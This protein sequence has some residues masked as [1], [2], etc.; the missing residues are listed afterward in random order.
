MVIPGHGEAVSPESIFQRPV[1]MDSGLAVARRP[2]MTR[3]TLAGAKTKRHAAGSNRAQ[4]SLAWP[5]DLGLTVASHGW[6]HL[7]PWVWEPETGTLRRLAPDEAV[8]PPSQEVGA[9]PGSLVRD[10]ELDE[11]VAGHRVEPYA[12]TSVR[13]RVPHQVGHRLLDLTPVGLHGEAARGHLDASTRLD[14]RALEPRRH[15]RPHPDRSR[16]CAG[17]AFNL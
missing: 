5:V 12:A 15:W 4:L 16:D 6:V 1:L 9:E 2:G 8:H 7:E 11:P 14:G 13:E 17:T 10:Q 3:E